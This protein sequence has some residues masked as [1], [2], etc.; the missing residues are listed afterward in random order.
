MI[1]ATHH[2]W[3]KGLSIRSGSEVLLQDMDQGSSYEVLT[4]DLSIR[5]RSEVSLQSLDQGSSQKSELS[6][7]SDIKRLM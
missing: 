3:I 2:P 7:R 5:F 1:K 4:R 6:Q